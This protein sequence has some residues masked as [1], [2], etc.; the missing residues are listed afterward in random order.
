MRFRR[1]ILGLMVLAGCAPA[2]HRTRVLY[3]EAAPRWEY[4]SLRNALNL[5]PS[6]DVH[7]FLLSADIE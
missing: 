1:A 7:C 5:D 6:F 2:P 4:R 3:L